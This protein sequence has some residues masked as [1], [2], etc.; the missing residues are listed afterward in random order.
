MINSALTTLVGHNAR[1]KGWCLTALTYDTTSVGG[2][3]DQAFHS[4][5]F[6][7][8]CNLLIDRSATVNVSVDTERRYSG[9]IRFAFAN[10]P[11][12]AN[13]KVFVNPT[14]SGTSTPVVAHCLNNSRYPKT[15][16][17]FWIRIGFFP[18]GLNSNTTRDAAMT[19]AGSRKNNQIMNFR[20]TD[21]PSSGVPTPIGGENFS[22]NLGVLVI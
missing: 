1:V 6:I 20:L 12:N 16:N 8:G 2:G 4:Y 5:N 3:V 11:A 14:F 15:V 9:A 18:T 21:Q 13:Y 17:G 10:E 7:N 22:L 19:A